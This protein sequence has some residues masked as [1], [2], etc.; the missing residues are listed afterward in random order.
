MV[1]QPQNQKSTAP[2]SSISRRGA[3]CFVAATFL[4]PTRA[5]AIQERNEVLCKTGFFTN[6]GQWYCTDIGNIADEGKSG[7]L[8][9]TQDKTADS[10]MSKVGL[11]ESDISSESEKKTETSTESKSRP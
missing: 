7:E 8:S 1:V 5:N 10:L 9:K 11:G 4:T 2:L 6:I 3:L